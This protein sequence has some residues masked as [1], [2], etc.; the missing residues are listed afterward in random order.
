MNIADLISGFVNEQIL[1]IALMLVAMGH[2]FT[3]CFKVKKKN[4]PLVFTFIAL[5][6][7][8]AYQL[9]LNPELHVY[10]NVINGLCQGTFSIS[11]AMGFYDL[12]KS[13]WKALKYQIKKA[14]PTSKKQEDNM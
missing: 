3:R 9:C 10:V 14:N 12:G 8:I 11:F 1:G 13:L 6:T 2:L 4:I 5:P 7:A